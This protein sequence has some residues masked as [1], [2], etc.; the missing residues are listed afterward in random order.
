MN[1]ARLIAV[2]GAAALFTAACDR[3]EPTSP[4]ILA[5][6]ASLAKV[7]ASCT[8][9]VGTTVNPLN[10]LH[11]LE[12]WI[13]DAIDAAG[14]SVNCGQTRSLDAKMEALTKALDQTPPN[15]HAACGISGAIANELSSLVANGQLVTPTF[16]PPFPGGPT[17]VV[18]AAQALNERWCA[19][20]RGE[21]VGPRS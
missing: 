14:S 21:L 6:T 17:N 20:A 4:S 18:S 7:G 2:A 12:G 11:E 8:V 9:D 13:G 15:F 3:A 5:S 10:A 19:A 1:R 16:P